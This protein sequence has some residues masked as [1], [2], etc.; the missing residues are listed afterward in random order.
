VRFTIP[1]EII[2]LDPESIDFSDQETVKALILKLL[3]IIESQA[4]LIEEQQKQIQSLKDEINRLKGEKG[5]PKFPPKAPEKI[6][7][8]LD[9]STNKKK[10]WTK[11]AKKPKIKI[12]R[13]EYRRVDKKIL[14]PDAKH[15]GY[16]TV[17]VQNIKFSTDNVEY[18]LERFYSSSENKLYE[19]ELPEG[20]DGEFHTDLKAFILYLYYACR[21]TEN[22]IKKILEESGVIISAGTISHI[23]TQEKKEELTKE[24][25]DILEAGLECSNYFHT[26]DTGIKHQGKSHH[27]HVICNDDF[28]V[29]FIMLKKDR[30]TVKGILG[31]EKDDKT[32]KIMITDDARQYLS[33]AIYHA[34]CWI[35]EIRLYKKLN[36]VID[37]HRTQLLYF[38]ARLWDFYNE[39]NKYRENP[40]EKEREKLEVEFDELF[41]TITGYEELDNRIALTRGKKEELLLVLKFPEIPPHNNPAEL[42]LRE[43][44]LKRKISNGTR[45]E[46]GKIAWENM[47]SILDTCRKLGVSFFEY[48]KDIFSG[49]YIMARLSQLISQKAA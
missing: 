12:D 39:L 18:K 47:M 37:Y 36:P 17:V 20:I 25:E 15:N 40:N 22:K 44:V 31:L 28:S 1:K 42:A 2:T 16:R 14:P 11:S 21:V 6:N 30:D 29:F 49:K 48:I 13:T 5:K 27:V 19:A 8:P 41:S 45:S 10:N 46:D 34:L 23:L 26:D 38:I 9:S 4:Q 7:D 35:H 43:F 33:I 3:N 24:K 32:D